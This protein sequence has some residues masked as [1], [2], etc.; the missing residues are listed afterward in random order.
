M[1]QNPFQQNI[2]MV[3]WN[4]LDQA[5][6]FG[7]TG[8]AICERGKRRT[9]WGVGVKQINPDTYATLASLFQQMQT[10]YPQTMRSAVDMSLLPTQGVLAVPD[11][12]TAYPWR[13]HIAIVYVCQ[14]C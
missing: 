8:A 5:S 10:Q 3:P 2:S 7:A 9:E 11:N 6:A 13:D 12:A 4:Q 14:F 1:D